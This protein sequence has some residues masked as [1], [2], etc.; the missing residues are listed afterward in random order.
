MNIPFTTQELCIEYGEPIPQEI[1]TKIW[2]HHIIP[3]LVVRSLL[4]SGIWASEHSGYRPKEWE[5]RQGRNGKS[6]HTFKGK[7]AVDW[8]CKPELL[9]QL[10]ELIILYTD[11]TRIAVY[12]NFIHCDYKADDGNRYLFDS[13]ENSQWKLRRTFKLN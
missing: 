5:F 9:G 7:G 3:M 13:D 6:E 10:L 1:A 11:Y 8:T 2:K 4:N 12:K